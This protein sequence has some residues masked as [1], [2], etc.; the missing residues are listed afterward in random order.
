MPVCL[1][2]CSEGYEII[3]SENAVIQHYILNGFPSSLLNA[4]THPDDPKIS[5][6]LQFKDVTS[7]TF[8]FYTF[9]GLV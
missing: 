2:V 3:L 8:P 6:G 9:N 4:P 1:A 7:L 5:P